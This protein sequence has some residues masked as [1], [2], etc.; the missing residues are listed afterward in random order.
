M[1]KAEK[2]DRKVTDAL[3]LATV[4]RP[5]SDGQWKAVQSALGD[6]DPREQVFQDLFWALLN[7]KEF[8]FNH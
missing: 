3:F 4:G 8:A 2:D 7:S 1:L 5:A 6:E